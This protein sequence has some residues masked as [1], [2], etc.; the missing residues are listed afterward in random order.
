MQV[1]WRPGGPRTRDASPG[2]SLALRPRLTTGVPCFSPAKALAG[3]RPDKGGVVPAPWGTPDQKSTGQWY[4]RGVADGAVRPGTRPAR[5]G[6]GG[7]RAPG[8]ESAQLDRRATITKPAAPP[9]PRLPMVTAAP[10]PMTSPSSGTS[11]R[12]S[13]FSAPETAT[14]AKYTTPPRM[15]PQQCL[16]A[17]CP[18]RQDPRRDADQEDDPKHADS[19][20][21]GVVIRTHLG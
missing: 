6:A 14:T 9:K 18:G 1:R 11:T 10:P 19:P 5:S 2:G 7:L 13:P 17:C 12:G 15:P 4:Q 8:G 20:N 3:W 21:H 16:P